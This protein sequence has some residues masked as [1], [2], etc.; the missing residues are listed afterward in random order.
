MNYRKQFKI[1]CPETV[2][3]KDSAFDDSNYIDWLEKNLDNTLKQ[4]KNFSL[5]NVSDSKVCTYKGDMKQET[6]LS[7]D[8]C[9][10]C[11]Y[12]S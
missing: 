10:D 5:G 3:E 2:G 8:G 9:L 6:C 7:S 12:Y 11:I 4:V 1:D